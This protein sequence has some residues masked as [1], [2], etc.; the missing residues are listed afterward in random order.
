[1]GSPNKIFLQGSTESAQLQ[2]GAD[3]RTDLSVVA[4]GSGATAAS[5]TSGKTVRLLSIDVSSS[6]AASLR[7]HTASGTLYRT[8]II[9]AAGSHTVDLANG[10]GFKA[11][12]AGDVT[13]TSSAASN[14]TGTISW[15]EE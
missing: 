6:G 14:L 15:V 10:A 12:D 13:V 7:F 1:M 8:P 5:P 11:A 9:P 3:Q 2:Y 4:A